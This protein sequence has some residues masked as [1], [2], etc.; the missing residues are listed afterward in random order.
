MRLS[1]IRL[2]EVFIKERQS[3]MPQKDVFFR[4]SLQ[5]TLANTGLVFI[6]TGILV[7][8]G[9]PT[10]DIRHDFRCIT[11]P[12]FKDYSQKERLTKMDLFDNR[13]VRA[14]N[15]HNGRLERG[16]QYGA[17]NEDIF[18]IQDYHN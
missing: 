12:N 15:F 1:I 16:M 13:R 17:Q 10:P 8:F 9:M 5:I 4:N 3:A 2:G 18:R 7:M 11:T 6:V 14:F